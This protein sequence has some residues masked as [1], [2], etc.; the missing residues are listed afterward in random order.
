MWD[1]A[2]MTLFINH[3]L[4][5]GFSLIFPIWDRGVTPQLHE[6]SLSLEIMMI[7]LSD[8]RAFTS[9]NVHLQLDL[10]Q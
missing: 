9:N 4:Y 10:L 8:L 6:P 2:L 7:H 5:M 1:L 3:P